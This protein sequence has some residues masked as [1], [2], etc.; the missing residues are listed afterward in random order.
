MEQAQNW[1]L[2]GAN[3]EIQHT[4]SYISE[5][6]IAKAIGIVLVILGHLETLSNPVWKQFAAMFHMPLFFFVYGIVGMPN[7]SAMPSI[8]TFI[9][10]KVMR[11]I[12]PYILWSLIY[13][14]NVMSIKQMACIAYGNNKVFA[15]AGLWFLP[16]IFV[17]ECIS[18][19]VAVLK[20]RYG[21]RVIYACGCFCGVFG[22]LMTEIG[23]HTLL[24]KYGFPFSFDI[25]LTAVVF[26]LIGNMFKAFYLD[27][28]V[29]LP[30][31]NKGKIFI[32]SLVL[33]LM[34]FI[35][36]RFNNGFIVD[37]VYTRVVM[38]RAS[39]GLYPLFIL[40]GVLGSIAT[41]LLSAVV[42][43]FWLLNYIGKNSLLYMCTNHICI[44]TFMFLLKKAVLVDHLSTPARFVIC[45]IA[46]CVVI[47][48]CTVL[49]VGIN[50][51]IPILNG[52]WGGKRNEKS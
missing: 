16:T 2:N 10:K 3:K 21:H 34:V 30:Q 22:Y 18:Y 45:M 52:K 43:P 39:Y 9:K 40:S 20:R 23:R 6:N 36:S 41:L 17:A 48:M 37:D 29:C 35:L 31:K 4:S 25:A 24:K 38:A 13:S 11:I 15:E 47:A 7:E 14:Y 12:I 46:L 5:I 19:V 32:A 50:R 49:S 27:K 26:V 1:N 33:Y 28:I 42:K 51:W 44:A 8:S